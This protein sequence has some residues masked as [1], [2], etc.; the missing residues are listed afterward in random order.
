[1]TLKVTPVIGV[2]FYNSILILFVNINYIKIS[3]ILNLTR[4]KE[5]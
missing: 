4:I 1:M 3:E 5:Y 2:T